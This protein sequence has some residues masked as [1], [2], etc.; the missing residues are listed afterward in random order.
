VNISFIKPRIAKNEI[1]YIR[2]VISSGKTWGGGEYS[3]GNSEWI[4]KKL[5]VKKALITN[6]AT[7]A[8]E[9]AAL[10]IEIKPGDEIIMPSYTFVS[11]ANAF[12]LRGGKP[13]FVDVTEETLN[14]NVDLIEKAITENTKAILIMNYAG[15]SCDIDKVKKISEKYN[16]FLIEDAAQ[17]ILARYRG[18]FLGSFG[19]LSCLSFHGTKNIS[20]GEGGALLINNSNFIEKAEI[21][22]EKGTNRGNF[23]KGEV[24]KYTWVDVGSSYLASEVTNAYLFAQFE[25]ADSINDLRIETWNSYSNYFKQLNKKLQLNF[26]KPQDFST[27]NGHIFYAILNNPSTKIKFISEMAKKGVQCTS[28]YV[29]LHSAPAANKFSRSGSEMRVTDLYWDKLV[30]FPIWSE[31]G[32]PVDEI[33]EKT[34]QI[35]EEII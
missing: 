25:E 34:G 32:L 31:F 7:D 1:P 33:L 8:L 19:D 16:L 13:V 22:L 9:M 3:K 4:S 12:V 17:S 14:I 30:R 18:G 10:L 23:I 24:D 5:G 28:H 29:P 2:S 15:F 21:I 26:T 6:S 27:H 20:C 35:L 11:S